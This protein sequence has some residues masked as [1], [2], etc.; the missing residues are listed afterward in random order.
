[1]RENDSFEL[2]RAFERWTRTHPSSHFDKASKRRVGFTSIDTTQDEDYWPFLEEEMVV[3]S[4]S[5][6]FTIVW[7]ARS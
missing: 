4:L 5:T 3:S 1:M 6:D 7:P 2:E